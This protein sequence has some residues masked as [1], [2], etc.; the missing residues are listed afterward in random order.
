MVH[1]PPQHWHAV[2]RVVHV[3]EVT[4]VVL[5]ERVERV[6]ILELR[7]APKHGDAR[8]GLDDTVVL[9]HFVHWA[10]GRARA[11]ARDQ[12]HTK[13][14][15]AVLGVQTERRRVQVP[16]VARQVVREQQRDAN[17]AAVRKRAPAD[18]YQ[19]INARGAVV[20]V[21]GSR[22]QEV[23]TACLLAQ[24]G[25]NGGRARVA[26]VVAVREV[27]RAQRDLVLVR[28]SDAV[29]AVHV[30]RLEVIARA[31]V[32]RRAHHLRRGPQ[33]LQLVIIHEHVAGVGA[34]ADLRLQLL[35]RRHYIWVALQERPSPSRG[36]EVTIR[37]PC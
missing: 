17:A 26:H 32:V 10:P 4:C 22:L 2:V 21:A 12:R 6:A 33:P 18:P 23:E 8:N 28:P 5:H 16:A 37:D 3:W 24:P 31:C 14:V 15:S 29:Y 11:D 27:V 19:H 30:A 36:G 1:V 7:E 9:R 34:P 35:Q 13:R 20:R 25:D